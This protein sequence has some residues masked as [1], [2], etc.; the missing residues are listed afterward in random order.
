[1]T[2][3]QRPGRGSYVVHATGDT[4]GDGW[5]PDGVVFGLGEAA[6]VGLTETCATGLEDDRA[7]GALPQPAMTNATVNPATAAI[8]ADLMLE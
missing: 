7:T 1:M 6:P 5:T 4:D 2:P 8:R 3:A